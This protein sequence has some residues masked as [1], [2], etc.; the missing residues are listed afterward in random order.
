MILISILACAYRHLFEK[1]IDPES[2]QARMEL[3]EI[4]EMKEKEDE[5]LMNQLE[6]Q[7]KEGEEEESAEQ[8][9][10]KTID[11]DE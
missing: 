3:K 1:M 7:E 11:I 8:S 9:S 4:R 10:N 6:E 5:E 2:Y